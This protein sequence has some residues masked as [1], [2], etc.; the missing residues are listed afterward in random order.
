MSFINKIIVIVSFGI[1]LLSCK[2]KNE[3]PKGVLPP[4]QFQ[5]VVWDLV[6][7]DQFITS[8]QLLKDSALDKNTA[9]IEWYNKVLSLHKVTEADF[10]ASVKYYQQR[11]AQLAVLMDS[12]S[13]KTETPVF[14]QKV[15]AKTAD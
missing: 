9:S 14:K 5:E 7:A 15:S 1:L 12:L 2:S 3:L 13:K 10:K 4:D 11:P 8:Y 6:R